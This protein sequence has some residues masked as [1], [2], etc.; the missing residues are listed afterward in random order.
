MP[1][2]TYKQIEIGKYIVADPHICRG[3]PTFRGTQVMVHPVLQGFER[4]ETIYSLALNYKIPP[5]AVVEALYLAAK[6]L[7]EKYKVPFPEPIV[8]T[9]ELVKMT[10]DEYRAL[11]PKEKYKRIDIGKYIVADP[12]ICHGKPTFRGRRV[13]VHLVLKSFRRK[14]TVDDI[15]SDYE[16]QPE[17][18]IEGFELAIEALLEKYDISPQP[19]LPAEELLKLHPTDSPIS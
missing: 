14:E 6:T 4:G 2:E 8:P 16:I 15:A 11:W 3:K 17:G 10:H 7:L 12:F 1:D 5:E 19:V 13:M 9:E 18:V